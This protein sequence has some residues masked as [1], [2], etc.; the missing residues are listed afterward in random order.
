MH[1]ILHNSAPAPIQKLFRKNENRNRHNELSVCSNPK[2]E[3]FK[4]S[5]QYSGAVLWNKL[6]ALPQRLTETETLDLFQKQYKRILFE[7]SWQKTFSFPK[8]DLRHNLLEK[9]WVLSCST[10]KQKYQSSKLKTMWKSNTDPNYNNNSY[11][12]YK[13]LS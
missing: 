8:A 6:A 7:T 13:R 12:N 4:K 1:K 2:T 11:K 3:L 10:K 5:L 9:N